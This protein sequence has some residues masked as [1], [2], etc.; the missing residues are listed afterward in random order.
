[1]VIR[2]VYCLLYMH[3]VHF[4]IHVMYDEMNVNYETF[5]IEALKIFSCANQY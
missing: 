2:F 5:R 4:I 1:M 3:V